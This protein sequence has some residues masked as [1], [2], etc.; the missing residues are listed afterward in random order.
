MPLNVTLAS[1]LLDLEIDQHQQANGYGGRAFKTGI[2]AL[3]KD[4]PESLWR[5]GDVVAIGTDG[6][7][8]KVCEFV[9]ILRLVQ[10]ISREH[11]KYQAWS[12]PPRHSGEP[13][14]Y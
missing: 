7:G 9:H 8:V 10:F 3:D 14:T 5:G 11:T 4:L 13:L 12:R 1:S 2:T 6:A